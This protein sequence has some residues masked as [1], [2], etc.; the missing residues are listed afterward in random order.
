MGTRR[1]SLK[2]VRH[3]IPRQGPDTSP[4]PTNSSTPPRKNPP[5]YV[6]GSKTKRIGEPWNRTKGFDYLDESRKP[7]KY[8]FLSHLTLNQRVTTTPAPRTSNHVRGSWMKLL[9]S[10]Y[11][12]HSF[13]CL[14]E[15]KTLAD[16]T[17][18]NREETI[19]KDVARIKQKFRH[20]HVIPHKVIAR[21]GGHLVARS[22][23]GLLLLFLQ[24][25]QGL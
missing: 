18:R 1:K 11:R 5:S 3:R 7:P 9:N 15:R 14:T 25:V 12:R 21:R 6:E 17:H 19:H 16:E 2:G 23:Q 22:N 4:R 13:I 24:C 20:G 8:A 10:K